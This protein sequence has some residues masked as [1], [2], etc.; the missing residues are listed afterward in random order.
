MK[1]LLTFLACYTIIAFQPAALKDVIPPI[2]LVIATLTCLALIGVVRTALNARRNVRK[3][4]SL[5][6]FD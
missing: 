2:S 3:G 5:I 6:A 1:I 4:R